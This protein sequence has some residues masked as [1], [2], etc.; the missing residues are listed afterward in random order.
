MKP[1]MPIM[2]L[3]ST[4][5]TRS[6]TMDCNSISTRRG[7]LARDFILHKNLVSTE[8]Q[9]Q[10]CQLL[11][12]FLSQDV[13]LLFSPSVM[14]WN[15]SKCGNNVSCVAICE[16]INDPSCVK[17]RKGENWGQGQERQLNFISTENAKNSD[18][19]QSYLLITN[20]EVV[21]VRYILVYGSKK[22]TSPLP[23][24]APSAT[25]EEVKSEY[26]T[27]FFWWCRR[28]PLIVSVFLYVS[29]RLKLILKLET[30]VSF[31][32]AIPAVPGWSK[33]SPNRRVLQEP[34][35]RVHEKSLQVLMMWILI[36]PCW[37]HSSI[38][39]SIKK[40]SSIIT[41]H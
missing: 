5:C 7:C 8:K 29:R 19:P 36:I 39:I 1:N 33:Q 35:H 34:S 12:V 31:I 2:A 26:R 23:T 4:T 28:N 24:S 18:I 27:G 30:K 32:L 25:N 11:T 16:Y 22:V 13:S 6:L 21:R 14:A 40:R 17:V 10:L 3:V 37:V 9:Q 15:K 20:N 38:F 41:L